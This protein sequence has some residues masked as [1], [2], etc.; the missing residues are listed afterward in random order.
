MKNVP[1][2]YAIGSLTYAQVCTLQ[3]IAFCNGYV[4]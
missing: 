4:W 2:T 3:N 1:Y